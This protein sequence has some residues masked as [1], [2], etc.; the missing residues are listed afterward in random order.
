M[1]RKIHNSYRQ[2]LCTRSVRGGSSWLAK[3][4]E[5]RSTGGGRPRARAR[6]AV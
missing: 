1:S 2:G 3:V 4:S 6:L 5:G